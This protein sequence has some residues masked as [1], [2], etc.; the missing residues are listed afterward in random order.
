MHV[1]N[2]GVRPNITIGIGAIMTGATTTCGWATTA[3]ATAIT[4]AGWAT[5]II[6]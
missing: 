5:A 6:G 4:G 1:F 2:T 3:P